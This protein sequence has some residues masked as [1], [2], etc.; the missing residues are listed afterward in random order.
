M[1]MLYGTLCVL[2]TTAIGA[3]Q[4]PKSP[5]PADAIRL[6]IVAH[7]DHPYDQWVK[8][9]VRDA[10]LAQLAVVQPRTTQADVAQWVRTERLVLE[11]LVRRTVAQA[12]SAQPVKLTWGKMPFPPKMYAGIR[13]AG[14]DYD[15][16]LVVIGKGQGH[17]Y[18]CVLFPP[19]CLVDVAVKPKTAEISTPAPP[20]L[21][22]Q[23]ART[24]AQKTSQYTSSLPT[25]QDDERTDMEV[26]FWLKE[27]WDN[28][29]QARP[30]NDHKQT[31]VGDTQG[32]T[33]KTRR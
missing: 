33:E 23:G 16:L 1:I 15:T 25:G 22:D 3:Q 9:R 8:K 2:F 11:S 30:K 17:N 28:R 5:I 4:G 7:S 21:S 19:L 12:G 13:V 32:A 27:W 31:T 29:G 18:W 6:R 26:R 14:G 10:L 20:M 24:Q